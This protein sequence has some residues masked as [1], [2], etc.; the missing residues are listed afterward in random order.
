MVATLLLRRFLVGNSEY[1]LPAE[2]MG[3]LEGTQI[4]EAP[5]ASWLEMPRQFATSAQKNWWEKPSIGKFLTFSW[6][7]AIPS[8]SRMHP[9]W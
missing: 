3:T 9:P 6:S 5:E 1:G 7:M 2:S 4:Q 8:F